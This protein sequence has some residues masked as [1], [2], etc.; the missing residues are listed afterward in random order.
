MK[1]KE[2]EKYALTLVHKKDKKCKEYIERLKHDNEILVNT[3]LAEKNKQIGE[4]KYPEK[5]IAEKLKEGI[6]RARKEGW[7]DCIK[8][9]E[10]IKSAIVSPMKILDEVKRRERQRVIGE[11]ENWINR[12][13]NW[14]IKQLKEKLNWTIIIALLLAIPIYYIISLF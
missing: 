8:E 11:L 3:I 7:N 4:L 12:D 14:T 2:L 6:E 1:N 9:Y 13:E 10:K 5:L